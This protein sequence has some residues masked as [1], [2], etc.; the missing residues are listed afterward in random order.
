MSDEA[1]RKE[2]WPLLSFY[3]LKRF[4]KRKEIKIFLAILLLVYI[5]NP[6]LMLDRAEIS[7]EDIEKA[8]T[9]ERQINVMYANFAGAYNYIARYAGFDLAKGE[10][11]THHKD[12]GGSDGL[13]LRSRCEYDLINSYLEKGKVSSKGEFWNF[14][15]RDNGKNLYIY[16][17]G[18]LSEFLL[19]DT[20][21]FLIDDKGIV[22]LKLYK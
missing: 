7:P 3:P 6:L 1:K 17:G 15:G 18:Y 12:L 9:L 16:R 10:R 13:K 8:F 14:I 21:K 20:S 22:Y 11:V 19:I 5:L 4:G 2:V